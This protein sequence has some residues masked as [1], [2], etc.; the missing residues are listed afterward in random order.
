MGDQGLS[1]KLGGYR[2]VPP[3]MGVVGRRTACIRRGDALM[4]TR[5]FV[6][7]MTGFR[8]CSTSAAWGSASI[9]S[10]SM[11]FGSTWARGRHPTGRE[12]SRE[13]RG[14]SNP[15]GFSPSPCGLVLHPRISALS[16]IPR[17]GSAPC[18]EPRFRSREDPS[19][20]RS[21]GAQRCGLDS[22]CACRMTAPC[23]WAKTDHMRLRDIASRAGAHIGV[24]D[25]WSERPGSRFELRIM[26]GSVSR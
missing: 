15:A 16:D 7:W 19:R 23:D 25:W 8:N 11:P 13:L 12:R 2:V 5:G 9:S 3:K 21:T 22:R 1:V 24:G 10:C 6:G 18:A 17:R 26:D 4:A 14:S 20:S